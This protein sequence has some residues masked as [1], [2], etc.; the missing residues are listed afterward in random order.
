MTVSGDCDEG[1]CAPV[2][3]CSAPP[4]RTPFITSLCMFLRYFFTF[5]IITAEETCR[6]PSNVGSCSSKEERWYYD[7]S[8]NEC[9]QF[10]YTGCGGN[11][12]NFMT[13]TQCELRCQGKTSADSVIGQG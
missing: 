10:D 5:E 12:N 11:A 2:P 13:E 6:L 4:P 9:R 7:A 8:S 3:E 1:K